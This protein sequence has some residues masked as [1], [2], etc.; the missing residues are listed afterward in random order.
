MIAVVV[1]LLCGIG[2]KGVAGRVVP[3]TLICLNI[4]IFFSQLFYRKIPTVVLVLVTVVG[5]AHIRT[6]IPIF[7]FGS[8]CFNHV[9]EMVFVYFVGSIVGING[10]NANVVRR[11]CVIG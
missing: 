7:P 9:V 3:E 2:R 6:T 11:G 1:K 4:V 10:T 8:V 5:K